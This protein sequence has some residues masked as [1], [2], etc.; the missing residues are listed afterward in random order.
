MA[1]SHPVSKVVVVGGGIFGVSTA[2]HLAR[3]GIETILVN[4]GPP[5][6][7][8]SGRS[9]AW[10]NSARKRSAEYH[11]LRMIGIER[12]RTL[13]ARYPDAAWLRFDGGLTWDADDAS[14][15]IADIFAHEKSLGY[16]AQHLSE[17]AIAS[18][19]P[20]IDASAVTPQGAI[21][22]P[23]EGW[24]DLPSLIEILIAEFV[25]R[26]G[27]L[28]T[29]AGRATV[30][31]VDGRATGAT[32][33]SGIN[34][35]ADAV[36][37]ATGGD[38]PRMVAASGQH[39]ADGTPIALL[40]R[41]KPV[42]LAL[43]AVLNTPR[44]AIR[45]TPDG[46]LALDSA[47][48]EEEVVVNSDGTYGVKDSTVQGLLNE[49]SK[50]LEGHPKLE[51]ESYGVGPKP[52]P[53]DGE[54]VFGQLKDIKEYYVAFSHSGATLGLIAG[55]LLAGEIASGIE[56]PLLANFRPARFS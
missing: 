55:E 48:S 37:L 33:T 26:G 22:N 21:F 41:T 30:T 54:P 50:V 44:V 9:L 23:G 3:L 6:K 43:R 11:R 24:V 16:G 7:G 35:P 42:D 4:D 19:T 14:N 25:E 47:W 5:A 39:I 51:L 52:I 49:A 34:F 20:G 18:V 31:V 56:N 46:A 2:V 53:A 1:I 27:R 32:T 8:A 13:S 10:L 45:P 29:D 28:V 15:E 40:V 17:G 36:L 12:Y 38:V